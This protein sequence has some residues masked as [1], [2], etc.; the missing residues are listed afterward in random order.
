[1]ANCPLADRSLDYILN[2]LSPSNYSEFDR[3]LKDDGLLIKVV[4]NS[5]YLY[6]LR[7]HFYGD[8]EAFDNE[9]TM[10][11]FEERFE[12]IKTETITYS[13]HLEQPLLNDLVK[14]TPL[15]WSASEEKLTQISEAAN[16]DITVDLNIL[17]GKKKV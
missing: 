2:I 5:D 12:L 9:K 3:L 14:M 8:R 4:P 6:E 16:M 17:I 1:M 15:S 13:V 7:E 11:R 10:T